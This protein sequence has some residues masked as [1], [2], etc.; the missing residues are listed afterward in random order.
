MNFLDQ[1][2]DPVYSYQGDL[3][4]Q[5]IRRLNFMVS[6]AL[7][8]SSEKFWYEMNSFK[9]TEEQAKEHI[10]KLQEFMPIMGLHSWPHSVIELG[11]AIQYQVDKDNL[12]ELRFKK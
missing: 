7:L 4:E 2:I 10:A 11:Q 3:T 12:H 8:N 5:T 6:T 9:F 1:L